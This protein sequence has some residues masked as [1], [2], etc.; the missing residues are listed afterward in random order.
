MI[1]PLSEL[2]VTQAKGCFKNREPIGKVR[3]SFIHTAA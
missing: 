2:R 1:E 3:K